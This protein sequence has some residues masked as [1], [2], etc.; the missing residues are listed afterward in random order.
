MLGIGAQL[1]AKGAF[2]I[3]QAENPPMILDICMAPGGLLS[4]ALLN[5]RNDLAF[6]LPVEDGGHAVLLGKDAPIDIRMVDITMLAADM[7]IQDIPVDHADAANFLPQQLHPCQLFDIALCDGQVLRT[8]PRASY[9]EHREA[10]RLLSTQLA[11]SLEHLRPGGTMIAL[12]HKVENTS[13]IRLLHQLSQI[14]NIELFKP[15][16]AHANRSSFYVIA[17][18]VRSDSIEAIAMVQ[19]WKDLWKTATFGAEEDYKSLLQKDVIWAQGILDQINQTIFE[20][21]KVIW[22]IQAAALA[23]TP[24]NTGAGKWARKA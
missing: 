21:A 18:E 12:F 24:Y 4:V 19:E 16:K 8:Q 3:F 20:Q 22:S 2:D 11:L 17:R 7:G 10:Q 9:R 6:S 23:K 14:A 1:R 13:T 15:L 5:N